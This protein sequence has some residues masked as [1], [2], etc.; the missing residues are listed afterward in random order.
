MTIIFER[1][2]ILSTIA[3]TAITGCRTGT[4]VNLLQNQR[5]LFPLAEVQ[6]PRNCKECCHYFSD[7]YD[8][9]RKRPGVILHP[10]LA[11]CRHF[12]FADEQSL[13]VLK[14]NSKPANFCNNNF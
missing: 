1:L 6:K 3:R 11:P 5:E 13:S 8:R 9:C 2:V 7:P 14:E 12:L 10:S 4:G